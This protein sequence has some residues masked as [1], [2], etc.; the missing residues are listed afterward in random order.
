MN[1]T[2][3]YYLQ[4]K[5]VESSTDDDFQKSYIQYWQYFNTKGFL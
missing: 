4:P 3:D 5:I 1:S 2:I